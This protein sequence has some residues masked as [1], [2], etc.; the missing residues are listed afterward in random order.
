MLFTTFNFAIF[1]AVCLIVYYALPVK[2][3]WVALFCANFV[4]YADFG[5]R[6]LFCMLISA[7]SVWFIAL[8]LKRV[9]SAEAARLSVEAEGLT[10]DAKKVLKTKFKHKRQL[11]LAACVLFNLGM[12]LFFKFYP[13]AA[14]NIA[15]LPQFN[16]L[17]PIGISF[18]TLSVLSYVIDVYHK[19][20]EAQQNPLKV[21]LFTMYFPQIIEG[22]ITRFGQLAPQLLAGNRLNYDTF[23]HG[24]QRILW[25]L[26]KKLVIADRIF[27]MVD[28]IFV[29]WDRYQGFEIFLGAVLYT[30]QLYADFSGGIDIAIG[31]SELFGITLPENFNR[32]FFSKSI[33]EFWRRWHITLG[34]WLKDYLFYPLTLSKPMAK[35]GKFFMSRKHKWAAK[36]IPSF[37]SLFIL[38]LC[39][40]IWHG[41]GMQYITF[42]L[43]HG[44]LIMLGMSLEPF[45]GRLCTRLGINQ[46]SDSFKL[47]RVV[48]T[49]CLVCYGE[50]IFRCEN[51]EQVWGMTKN[52]FSR[53]NFYA[54]FDGTINR[55][56]LEPKEVTI[57]LIAIAVLFAVEFIAR[58]ID[59]GRYIQ[60]QERPIRWIIYFAGLFV[61][62]VFGAY[63][64]LFSNVPFIYFQF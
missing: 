13:L 7:V 23:V 52:L 2:Y 6:R 40:G 35:L 61:V 38:W 62:V 3:R 63:G 57:A 27:I 39:N 32:P 5:K 14:R 46:N 60:K 53:F 37:I 34:A 64:P 10:K 50:L 9:H 25:G 8:M 15:A 22:P 43:Y 11:L 20:I 55:L 29:Y 45:C 24:L 44:F 42:G 33:G 31:V 59:V 47:W 58:R 56:E 54:L 21:I 36:W 26:F 48:R 28:T 51:L 41:E 1:V 4:F 19:K 18:Y 30:I 12:L 49:F 16:L 17:V